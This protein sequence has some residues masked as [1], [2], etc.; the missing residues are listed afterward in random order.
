VRWLNVNWKRA[1]DPNRY[2]YENPRLADQVR[3]YLLET[4]PDVV[5][6]TSCY[7]L[8]ARVLHV[9]KELQLPLA[10][11]LTDFW[12]LCPRLD[13][14]RGDG[15]L[16]DARTT[17]WDCLSCTLTQTKAYRYTSRVLPK[18]AARLMLQE[19]SRHPSLTRHPGL[20]GL[21]MDMTHRK[22]FLRAALELPDRVFI[23]SS[24]ARDIFVSSGVTRSIA[25]EPYGLDLS[26]RS[27]K[28]HKNP[29]RTLRFGFIGRLEES[30]GAHLLLEAY[31]Q[32]A[33]TENTELLI[34]GDLRADPK[35]A[36]RLRGYAGKRED[37]QF[38]GIYD[39]DQTEQIFA[40]ID[41]LIVPSLW[42]DYPL[43]VL[44]AFATGTPVIVTDVGSMREFVEHE[45]NG[46]LFERGNIRALAD[47]LR[48]CVEVPGLLGKLSAGIG[49]VR[50]IGDMVASFETNYRELVVT[51][52]S[53]RLLQ[54]ASSV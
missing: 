11:T 30:K 7:S 18:T 38:R 44:E 42:Y 22:E 10:L 26:W 33:P 50:T 25:L 23:A 54:E 4:R 14:V 17:A 45:S 20:R 35:Y 27:G 9:V 21:A 53:H 49:P 52:R 51:P 34:Y 15:S 39:H 6:I 41:V 46:L 24:F 36:V 28:V 19:V 29:S 31:T 13:L 37:I 43:V 48:R 12:F 3:E 5:H 32:L 40:G 8:S 1:P 2:L 47:A 16:C